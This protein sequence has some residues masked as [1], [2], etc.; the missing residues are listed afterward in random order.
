PEAGGIS[1]S[2]GVNW[3]GAR[4]KMSETVLH[5]TFLLTR[6]KRCRSVEK[7]NSHVPVLSAFYSAV[8]DKNSI[9]SGN[10]VFATVHYEAIPSFVNPRLNY[11]RTRAFSFS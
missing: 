2:I 5:I 11:F 3:A 6:F 4:V 9:A 1:P 7:W 10:A 8:Q